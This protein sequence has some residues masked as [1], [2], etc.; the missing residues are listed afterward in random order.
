MA[1]TAADFLSD[2]TLRLANPA[3]SSDE[4][5]SYISSSMREVSPS[6]YPAAD[7]YEQVLDTACYKLS[8]DNKFPEIS[9][10]SQNGLSTS[11]SQNDPER[12]RRRMTERRQA[13]IMGAGI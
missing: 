8:I 6:N 7:Y 1:L 12:F 10:V 2:L 9:S 5:L 11:F 13:A 3:V 4:L